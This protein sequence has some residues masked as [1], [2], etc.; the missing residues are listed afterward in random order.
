M[1][2]EELLAENT[3][4]VRAL[5]AALQKGGSTT[6]TPTP[7]G[8]ARGPGRPKAVTLDEVKAAAE[9]VRA[10]K[11]KPAAVAIIKAHGADTLGEL[12]KS[13]YAAFIAACEVALNEGG[14]DGDGDDSL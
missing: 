4:A 8:A 10:E 5:T 6:A 2:L 11:D 14:D 13:K 1:A 9:K 3:L 7:A 12:D